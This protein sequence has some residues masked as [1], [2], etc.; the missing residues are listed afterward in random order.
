MG[1]EM[2]IRDR[3]NWIQNRKI[4]LSEH[5]ILATDPVAGVTLEVGT[6]LYADD[7][8]E[9]NLTR[10]AAAL[11]LVEQRSTKLLN[12]EL[13]KLDMAQNIGESREYGMLPGAQEQR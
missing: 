4:Q 12:D 13:N 7:I 1:S 8:Q 10:N 9:T 11:D 6:T 2:C 3:H 5:V